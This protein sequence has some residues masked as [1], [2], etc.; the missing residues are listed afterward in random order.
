MTGS[1]TTKLDRFVRKVHI[2]AGLLNFTSVMICGMAGL[3]VTFEAP[4]IFHG[5]AEKQ[6][7]IRDFTAP[8]IASDQDLAQAIGSVVEHANSI[9]PVVKRDAQH[10]LVV[11]FYSV[12]G[13]KRVTV[14][15]SEHQLRIETLRNS[16]WRFIDNLHATTIHEKTEDWAIR[17]WAWYMELSIWCLI[18]MTL[19][20]I[21][22]GLR[23]RSFRLG[24]VSLAFGLAGA[25]ALFWYLR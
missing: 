21:W 12:N 18:A 14:S 13:L 2:Y 20:G 10:Q 16:G 25:S 4:D 3:V 5:A 17:G 7:E 15:E 23:R 11:D 22:M 8:D 24:L 6:V 19:T 9:A 1:G